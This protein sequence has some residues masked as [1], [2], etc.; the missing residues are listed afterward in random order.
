M[1][2]RATPI[3]TAMDQIALVVVLLLSFTLALAG[4]RGLLGLVLQAMNRHS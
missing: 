2:R 3:L 1:L 4:A